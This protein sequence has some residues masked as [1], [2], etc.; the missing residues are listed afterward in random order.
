MT[1]PE[2]AVVDRAS[3]VEASEVGSRSMAGYLLMPRPKDLVKGLLIPVTYGI[4]LLSAGAVTGESVLRAVVVLLAVELLVYPARYQWNDIRGFVADQLHPS[5]SDRGR[6]PGPLSCARSRILTSGSVA[7]ARL[8]TAAALIV[9]L[10]GLNLAGILTFATLGVFAVAIVYEVLRSVG[11]GRC[12]EMPPPVTTGIVSL[13]ITV[14]AGYVVRGIT[15]L[16]LAVDLTERPIL[17]A[18]AVVTLWAYGIAFVTSR[19]ALEATAFASIDAGRVTWRAVQGQAREHLLALTRWLPAGREPTGSLLDWPPLAGRTS[20]TAP[21]NV[22][23][24]VAGCAAGVTGRLLCGPCSPPEGAITAVTGGVLAGVAITAARQRKSVVAIGAA[25]L[26]TAMV[27]TGAPKPLLGVVPWLLVLGAH[28]FFS[29]RTLRKLCD[30]GPAAQVTSAGVAMLGRLV[31]GR[32]TWEAIH[33]GRRIPQ[34]A[35]IPCG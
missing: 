35:G 22:A 2:L 20:V 5:S 23:M 10:P 15:G 13:W 30:G 21:W 27:L 16:A 25:I 29:T 8:V 34:R 28:L 14:G 33:P 17:A 31:L 3:A 9:L 4:G 6:L 26:L 1:P 32:A 18:A 19:W 12:T 7:A 11:T 24:L